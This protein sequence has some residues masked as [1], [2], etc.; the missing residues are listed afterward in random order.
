MFLVS[1]G[2]VKLKHQGSKEDVIAK[3]RREDSPVSGLRLWSQ[4]SREGSPTMRLKH[5]S[6]S[7][8]GSPQLAGTKRLKH[9]ISKDESTSSKV[10]TL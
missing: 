3:V 2:S 5:S 8:E 4:G 1:T 7:R 9:S 6:S 10:R